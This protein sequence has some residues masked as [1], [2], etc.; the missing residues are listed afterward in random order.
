MDSFSPN[1][2]PP[3]T[4]HSAW[5]ALLENEWQRHR[6]ALTGLLLFWIAGFW[7]LLLFPHP[8]FHLV[9]GLLYGVLLAGFQ[10]GAD[11]ID[12]TEE[13]SFSLP[14]GRGPLFPRE[15]NILKRVFRQSGK[16]LLENFADASR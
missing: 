10:A 6:H 5:F 16:G 13:F 12:G 3:V 15:K 8:A 4:D 2:R 11:V 7:I 9:V 1:P 14:P